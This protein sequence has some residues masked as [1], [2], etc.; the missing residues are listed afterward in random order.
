MNWKRLLESISE[1]LND[2]LRLRNDYLM[3]ENRILRNRINGRVQFTDNDRKELAEIGTKLGK[4]ALAE[5]ATVATPGT[6]LA[7]N[8]KFADPQAESSQSP[9]SLCR[10]RIAQEIEDLVIRMARENRSWGYDR[11][12]GALHHLGDTLSD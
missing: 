2:D 4:K 7:W 3:A 11:M 6:I 9:K 5:I 1:S 10:P 12:Q 8:R